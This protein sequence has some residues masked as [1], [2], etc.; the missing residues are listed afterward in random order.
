MSQ[1]AK[2]FISTSTTIHRIKENIRKHLHFYICYLSLIVFHPDLE[3][4]LSWNFWLMAVWFIELFVV[5]SLKWE[6]LDPIL[7]WNFLLLFFLDLF[8]LFLFLLPHLFFVQFLLLFLFLL[9]FFN[10]FV[11]FLVLPLF[12]ILL[13]PFFPCLFSFSLILLLTDLF[14]PLIF[15]FFVHFRL[16][17]I[18]FLLFFFFFFLSVSSRSLDSI[19]SLEF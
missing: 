7:N 18:F 4:F 19:Y 16:F 6:V 12:L 5:P 8:F 10:L 1:D 13:F 15:L 9:D 17:L 2:Y 14:L 3:I 11:L